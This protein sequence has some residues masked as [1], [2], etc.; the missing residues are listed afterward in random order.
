MSEPTQLNIPVEGGTMPADVHLP[1]AGRGPGIVLFQEIFGVSDY[2]TQRAKDLAGQGYVVV[3]P[4]LYWR[5]DDP[6]VPDDQLETA[7]G[8]LQRFDWEAGV[9]DGAAALAATR[10]LGEA[11]GPTGLLGFCFGGGLAF[12]VAA[13]ADPGPDALV[14]YYGSA[15]PGLLSLAPRV[16]CPSLH[17]F[18]LEDTF[19][20]EDTVREIEAAVTSG[21]GDAT[22]LTYAGAGHAFDNPAPAFHHEGAS[23]E[24][25]AATVAWLERELPVD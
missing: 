22:F 10:A 8:L 18:G 9:A 2:I 17:H 4:H 25:W 12:N 7:M 20:P 19:I 16:T 21:G 5:L 14:S 1:E 24:A 6:V 3:V 15:L 13:V 23:Q 11:E